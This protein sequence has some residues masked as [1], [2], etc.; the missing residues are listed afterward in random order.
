MMIRTLAIGEFVSF[1]LDRK[2][3]TTL[4]QLEL[5]VISLVKLMF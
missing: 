5:L 3:T 4:W 1:F 2:N